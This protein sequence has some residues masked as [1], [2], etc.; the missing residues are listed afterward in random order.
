MPV[1]YRFDANIVVIDLVGEYSLEDI[2]TAMLNSFADSKR[3]ANPF[4][5]IDMTQSLSIYK[6]SSEDVKTMAQFVAS[7]RDRFNNRV[8]LVG[9]ADL[10]YGFMRMAAVGSEQMG[11]KAEVFRTFTKA[12]EWLLS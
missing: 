4:L 10:P 2:R 3:P 5:L 8:A 1:N 6:R 12:R 9:P 7:L 11:I